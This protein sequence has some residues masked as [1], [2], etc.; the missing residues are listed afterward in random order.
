MVAGRFAGEAGDDV[1]ADGGVREVFADE[2][3]A[4]GVVLGAIPAMHGGEDAVGAGLQRHVEVLGDALRGSKQRD[5][6][7]RD[8]ER[9]D[10]ADAQALDGRFGED[11]RS[12]SSNS[13]RGERSRP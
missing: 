7:L 6:I 8:V 1:G 9:L 10:R 4:A 11:A 3:D 5:Q 12:R 2:L 13:R